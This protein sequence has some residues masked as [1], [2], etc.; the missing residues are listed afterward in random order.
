MR[1]PKRWLNVAIHSE[2]LAQTVGDFLKDLDIYFDLKAANE[3]VKL[4]LA[5]RAIQDPL[6]KG[7]LNAQNHTLGAYNNL[8][9]QINQLLWN[10]FQQANKRCRI[11]QDKFG[12]KCS[13]TLAGHYL[14]YANLATSLQPPLSEYS[15]L[16][17]LTSH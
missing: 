12:K 1:I 13:E 3:K 6:A 8:K 7:C 5:A 2:S 11:F 17:T 14:R 4:P 9:V 15:L 16:S 10:D